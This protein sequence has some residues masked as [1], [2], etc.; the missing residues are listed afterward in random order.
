[1]CVTTQRKQQWVTLAADDSFKTLLWFKTNQ[2]DPGGCQRLYLFWAMFPGHN[3]C[4]TMYFS[5]NMFK[6]DEGS[7]APPPVGVP[8][9]PSNEVGYGKCERVVGASCLFH[10]CFSI[11]CGLHSSLGFRQT[12]HTQPKQP[13]CMKDHRPTHQRCPPH[14]LTV[15]LFLKPTVAK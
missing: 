7:T 2:H 8:P 5:M 1:M 15:K 9:R 6:S 14:I 12:H 13:D 3:V 4:N 10:M 11:N